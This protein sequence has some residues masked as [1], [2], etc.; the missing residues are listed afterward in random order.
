TVRGFAVACVGDGFTAAAV[1]A[2][3]EFGHHHD[4]FGLTATAD[5]E[6]AGNWPALDSYGELHA[7]SSM[8][9]LFRRAQG[10]SVQG[11]LVQGLPA[12]GLP[13]QGLPAQGLRDVA[14]RSADNTR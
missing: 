11:V 13:A 9:V 2:I 5:R 6:G 1:N 14:A 10:L 4:G 3:V 12:Q 8:T 7:R